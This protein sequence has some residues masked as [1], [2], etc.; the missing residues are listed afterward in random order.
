M[1]QEA[2]TMT[3]RKVLLAL[4]AGGGAAV[5]TVSGVARA[6]AGYRAPTQ[7]ASPSTG[8]PDPAAGQLVFMSK[9]Q[10]VQKYG[11][12]AWETQKARAA[13]LADEVNR[14]KSPGAH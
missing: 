6:N 7:P 9:D 4:L 11:E 8:R 14:K 3:R 10:Y 1:L 13:A 2:C 5:L 12:T